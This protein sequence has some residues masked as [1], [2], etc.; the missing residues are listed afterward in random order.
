MDT[1]S[2][3]PEPAVAT[4]E[5]PA[6]EP[7]ARKFKFPTAFTVLFAVLLLVWIAWFFVPAGIYDKSSSGSPVPGTYHH[8]PSCSAVAAGGTALVVDSPGET[9]T[10]PADAQQAPGAKV[11]PLLGLGNA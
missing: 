9:G 1:E 6:A 4:P 7:P 11:T 5:Q 8:L 10:A 2:V 3:A